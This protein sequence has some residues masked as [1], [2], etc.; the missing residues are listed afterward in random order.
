MQESKQIGFVVKKVS[1][2][3]MSDFLTNKIGPQDSIKITGPVGHYT[4]NK[5][6]KKYLLIST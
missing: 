3:G 6:Y 4:D 5:K 1:K 2:D